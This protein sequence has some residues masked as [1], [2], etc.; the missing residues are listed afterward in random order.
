VVG[1]SSLSKIV[2]TMTPMYEQIGENGEDASP[3]CPT[4]EADRK[5]IKN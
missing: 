5:G 1:R 2:S 3:D 4:K